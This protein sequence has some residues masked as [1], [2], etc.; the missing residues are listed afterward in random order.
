[1]YEYAID[2]HWRPR[3]DGERP[4]WLMLSWM[5]CRMLWR[6]NW[7][8]VSCVQVSMSWW[9]CLWSAGVAHHVDWANDTISSWNQFCH[10]HCLNSTDFSLPPEPE[11]TNLT[12]V[13]PE[14]LDMKAVF[15][16]SHAVSLPPHRLH[17]IVSETSCSKPWPPGE[18]ETWRCF[19][20]QV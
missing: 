8:H 5:A 2:C 7:C 20:K 13:P 14:Y 10:S 11:R 18:G 19:R 9:S 3:V 1:M 16:K 12:S 15:S 6:M 4:H 17:N